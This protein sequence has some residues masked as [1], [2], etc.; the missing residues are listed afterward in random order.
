MFG[1]FG[2]YYEN[3][4]V[5]TGAGISAESGIATFRDTDGIWTRVDP[6]KV[7]T[8]EALARDPDYC[9]A[10]YNAM[11]TELRKARPNAAHEALAELEQRHPGSV[12]VVTQN[13]DN[14]HRMAGTTSIIHMHGEMDRARCGHCGTVMDLACD[15]TTATVCPACGKAGL[16][17]PH[18]VLFGEMPFEMERIYQALDSCDLFLSIGTSGNVYPAAGFVEHLRFRRRGAHTVELNLEPSDG[19]SLFHESRLGK[20]TE[21]VPVYV[22]RLL[23]GI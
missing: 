23:T 15:L 14:L 17:R 20:A 5:L 3:I 8:P 21:V 12:L 7:A 22:Q 18:V 1:G 6:E 13:V 10:F 4:V 16:M 9:H 11:R 19:H 2:R